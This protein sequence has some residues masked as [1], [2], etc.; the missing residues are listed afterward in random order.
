MLRRV[1]ERLKN[2]EVSPVRQKG[3]RWKGF[4]EKVGLSQK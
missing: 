4:V 2:H 3:L 1:G